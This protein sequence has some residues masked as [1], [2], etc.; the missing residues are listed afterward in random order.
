MYTTFSPWL[1]L[2][3][4]I[5]LLAMVGSIVITVKGDSGEKSEN[6]LSANTLNNER[7]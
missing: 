5:L 7:K 4:L 3:G 1:I 6:V 2:V